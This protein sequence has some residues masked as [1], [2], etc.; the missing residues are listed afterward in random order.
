[1]EIVEALIANPFALI[2]FGA[3]L[4][5]GMGLIWRG[6]MTFQYVKYAKTKRDTIGTI[7]EVLR[8]FFFSFVYVFLGGIFGGPLTMIIGERSERGRRARPGP[9]EVEDRIV[10]GESAIF[11][12]SLRIF[13]GISVIL[14]GTVAAFLIL[15]I[16]VIE[17]S[18]ASK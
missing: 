8:A 16:E 14:I 5:L 2:V 6:I 10:K 9:E 18:E 15:L 17:A 1:M 11:N 4:L 13:A 7:G 12:G 3:S